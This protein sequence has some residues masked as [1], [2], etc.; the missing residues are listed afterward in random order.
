MN[1]H[2]SNHRSADQSGEALLLPPTRPARIV[3]IGGGSGSS[4][5][6]Q[7]LRAFDVE[8]TAIVTM[9]D[10]GG[11]SGSLRNEFGYPPFGDLRQC[12]LALSTE[13][14]PGTTLRSALEF[15]FSPGSSLRGHNLGNLFLA[16]LTSLSNLEDAIE[17]LRQVLHI[18]GHVLPVS[19][20]P[21]ELCA[22]LQDGTT[23]RGETAIDRRGR[24]QSSITRVFLEPGVAANPRAVQAI[25]DADAI[26]LGPGDLY[27]S[28][29]P[30]LLV[31]GISEALSQT[32]APLIYVCNLMTKAGE[33]DNFAASHFVREVHR[34]LNGNLIDWALVN[35]API[36]P[37]VQ[38]KYK[39][40][41]ASPV[42]P[43]LWRLAIQGVKTLGLECAGMQFP[44]RHNPAALAKSILKLVP[45]NSRAAVHAAIL[46][47]IK[48]ITELSA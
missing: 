16:A 48:E 34:Y 9:F 11:S 20:V 47:T 28:L 40:E 45:R 30:N 7:G 6:L 23:I 10:S 3:V 17:S 19:L 35:T 42:N 33:T 46:N 44:L 18:S 38:A 31:D 1:M 26:V 21:A 27:T 5:V 36:C 22:V 41:G 39:L 12:L 37:D 2:K 8:L 13:A 32:S 15:R 43:D 4:A 29:I 14:E 24:Y 25:L